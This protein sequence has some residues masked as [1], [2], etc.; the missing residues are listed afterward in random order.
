M[1]AWRVL[2][3]A[4]LKR[5][6]SGRGKIGIRRRNVLRSSAIQRLIA[7]ETGLQG[8]EGDECSFPLR[9]SGRPTT[10]ASARRMAPPGPIRSSHRTQ[11]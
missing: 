11:P 10:A 6:S 4:S 9:S 2:G 8:H 7:A 5:I 3:R 1:F